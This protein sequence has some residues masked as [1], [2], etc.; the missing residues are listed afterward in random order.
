MMAGFCA[1]GQAVA[2]FC[3]F[4]PTDIVPVMEV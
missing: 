4:A 3:W 1:F 2:L